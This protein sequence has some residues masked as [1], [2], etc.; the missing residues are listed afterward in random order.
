MTSHS[1]KKILLSIP[2]SLRL[3]KICY[4][5]GLGFK[6][7]LALCQACLGMLKPL[8][9]PC[10]ICAEPQSDELSVYCLNCRKLDSNIHRFYAFY[11]Y[12]YPLDKL[13]AQF[14]FKHH[15]GLKYTLSQIVLKQLPA[16]ALDT[17]CLIPVPLHPRKLSKRGYHQ[18]LMLCQAFSAKTGIPYSLKYCQKSKNTPSQ[19][20]L[21]KASRQ[22]NL[23]QAFH[24]SPLPFKHVTIIDDIATTGATINAVAMGLQKMGVEKIDVW[25]LAKV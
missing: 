6:T 23:F 18:T 7:D 24:F 19:M 11:E 2:Q 25:C 17:E 3:R 10:W 20:K 16:A 15:Y 9:N 13:I 12:T 8:T 21:D 4:G 1:R 14:K 22:E 5:C